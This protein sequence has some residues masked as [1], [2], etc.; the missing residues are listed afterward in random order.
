[1]VQPTAWSTLSSLSRSWIDIDAAASRVTTAT[2]PRSACM[3]VMR[4]MIRP[5]TCS[6]IAGENTGSREI[7][8]GSAGRLALWVGAMAGSSSE[9]PRPT[10]ATAMV[11]ARATLSTVTAARARGDHGQAAPPGAQA[12]EGADQDADGDGGRAHDHDV[13]ERQPGG[14]RPEHGRRRGGDAGRD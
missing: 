12:A 11:T 2:P 13:A 5:T 10:T 14:H 1:V 4:V 8:A 3:A 7:S 9:V 6:L